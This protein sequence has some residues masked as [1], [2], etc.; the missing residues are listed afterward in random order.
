MFLLGTNIV[1]SGA[2]RVHCYGY[3]VMDDAASPHPP[4]DRAVSIPLSPSTAPGDG[5]ASQRGLWRIYLFISVTSV[6]LAVAVLFQQ[7]RSVEQG[8]DHELEYA[9]RLVATSLEMVMRKY[10]SLLALVGE[11]LLELDGLQGSDRAQAVVDVLLAR[12]PE[13][14]GFGLADL[15]GRL[16]LTSSNID[17]TRLPDLSRAPETADTFRRVLEADR[18]VVGRTYFMPALDRWVIPMRYPLRDAGGRVVAVMTTGL[19]LESSHS[20][21]SARTLPRHIRFAVVREDFYRQYGS[22]VRPQDRRAFYGRPLP[23]ERVR[24][25]E[26]QAVARTGMAP[27]DLRRL[28]RGFMLYAPDY[29]ERWHRVFLSFEPRY[30]YY[31][32]TG[33]P[34]SVL[35]GRMAVPAGWTVFLLLVLNGAL[36]F[37]FRAHGR[38][39]QQA[40]RRLAHLASHDQLTGLPNR[41]QL[42]DSFRAWRA[43]SPGGACILYIDLD[44]FKSIND[45]H[46]HTVGD[47]ILGEVATRL[48]DCFGDELV[49]RQG[50]DE[51]I[52][53]LGRG[54]G[55]EVERRCRAFLERLRAPITCGEFSFSVRAS[56]GVAQSPANGVELEDLLRKADMAMY[57]AK[58][59]R[60]GIHL[61]TEQLERRNERVGHIERALE[62]ALAQGEFH[63]AYQPQIDA[64]DG[65]IVG[66]EA[67]LR[68]DSAELGAVPPDEF[69]PVAEAMGL[70]PELGRFVAGR[71]LSDGAALPRGAALRIAVNASV[72]QILAPGFV[73]ELAALQAEGAGG[74]H[75]LVVEIT[76]SLFIE[77]VDHARTVL[78][79]LRARSIGVSLDD[80]GTG[81]SSLSLLSKLPLD[82]LKIDKSFVRDILSDEQDHQLVRSII[83][84]GDSLGIPVLAEGV[85]S[86][87]QA[88]RLA[89]AGCHRF[90]GY[91]FARPMTAGA[92]AEFLRRWRGMKPAALGA[93]T[94]Q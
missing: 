73:D 12:N 41:R 77:D 5:L 7:W 89:A 92:L 79:A 9:G 80:F 35:A 22:H 59:L 90:Q 2:R 74:R 94:P 31:I 26:R 66:I 70:M 60:T 8:A 34:V 1:V 61:Y 72:S 50:G 81:Y 40:A 30:R 84:L 55:T 13:L 32:A 69:V 62:T 36:Y 64:R 20:L 11:R 44:N 3:K 15:R 76:E 37:I 83:G 68:W 53:L 49:A 88:R 38:L 29:R 27:D 6:V 48:A 21:W 18:M 85:E 67:L 25:Y 47:V 58:R 87:E 78:Q 82:E 28:G 86:A 17:R 46:G 51:F 93:G 91:F 39:Q 45:L 33:M 14:A 10:E 42:Q 57:E 43:A 54:Y 4:P 63:V 65:R 24:F 19:K 52:V 75:R 16:V 23:P 71:A 56:I